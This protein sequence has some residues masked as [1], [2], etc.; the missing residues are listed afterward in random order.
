MRYGLMAHPNPPTT[1]AEAGFAIEHSPEDWLFKART[2]A[3][4]RRRPCGPG[5]FAALLPPA[6]AIREQL[7]WDDI[8]NH[9]AE[10]DFAVVFLVLAERL[11][12]K[13]AVS[14]GAT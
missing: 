12:L 9:T 14:G 13:G 10:H 2:D 5:D 3:E 8:E 7:N 11:G 1:L 4:L 6:R